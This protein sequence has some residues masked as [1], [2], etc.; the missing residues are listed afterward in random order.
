MNF[1]A[2]YISCNPGGN[3]PSLKNKKNTLWRYFLYFGKQNFLAQSLK[4]LYIFS[5][6]NSYISGENLQSPKN[7]NFLRFGKNTCKVSTAARENSYKVSTAARENTYEANTA[8]VKKKLN[9]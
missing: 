1:L 6:K 7:K 3:F 8:K 4:T 9:A 2:S 5:K